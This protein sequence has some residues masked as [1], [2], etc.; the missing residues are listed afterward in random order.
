MSNQTI[1][2][3]KLYRFYAKIVFNVAANINGYE[4]ILD[5]Q[6][7][8]VRNA[9]YN[10]VNINKYVYIC[11]GTFHLNKIFEKLD[12]INFD[13]K[14]CHLVSLFIC[15]NAYYGTIYVYGVKGYYQVKLI[16]NIRN[17]F[18]P[19]TDLYVCDWKNDFEG[20]N[21]DIAKKYC[22]I[23]DEINVEEDR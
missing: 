11:K 1:S 10:G 3:N 4:V 17:D 7:D 9:I 14:T 20:S 6:F 2:L 21:V 16:E 22:A 12:G 18:Y 8:D 13:E 5:S 19:K 15:D 23:C